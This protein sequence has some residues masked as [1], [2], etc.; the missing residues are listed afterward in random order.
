MPNTE[1]IIKNVANKEKTG[2]KE[3]E[4]YMQLVVFDLDQEEYAVE[5]KDLQEIIKIPDITPI[6]NT[7]VFIRGIFNLR[8]KIIVVI[9]LEK[10]FNLTRDEGVKEGNIIVAEVNENSFG[11]IVD[12]VTEIINVP[13]SAIQQTPAITSSKIH[14]EYLKGVVVIENNEKSIK[15]G[16]ESAETQ[17][18]DSSRLIILLNLPK[19]LQEKELLSLGKTVDEAMS[20]GQ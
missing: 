7:P 10:R 3:V 2:Q 4:S 16:G 17:K 19:M 15:V 18:D 13:T 20:K 5:I 8:G 11:I 1:E 6:P 14:A 12:K 9:D